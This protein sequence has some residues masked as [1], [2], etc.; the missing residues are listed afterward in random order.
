MIVTIYLIVLK[1]YKTQSFRGP[2]S[3]L[4]KCSKNYVIKTQVY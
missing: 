3:D 1:Q 4:E 2:A